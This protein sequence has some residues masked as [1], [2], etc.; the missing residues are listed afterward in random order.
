MQAFRARQGG[1]QKR[2]VR[3]AG[4]LPAGR[5]LK[6]GA[7]EMAYPGLFIAACAVFL[8]ADGLAQPAPDPVAATQK[9]CRFTLERS[10]GSAADL[11]EI[12]VIDLPPHR[13]AHD[14]RRLGRCVAP[15]GSSEGDGERVGNCAARLR[16]AMRLRT[17]FPLTAAAAP[18]I[19]GRADRRGGVKGGDGGK[20]ES[21]GRVEA[22]RSARSG[23]RP[24]PWRASRRG[25]ASGPVRRRI[26]Q[27]EAGRDRSGRGR[28]P[29][30]SAAGIE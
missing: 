22:V 17:A 21:P 3:R 2:R 19:H 8:A 9:G 15:G 4:G 1:R 7:A 20:G 6:P 25:R 18:V 12:W 11:D 30:R 14:A 27:A 26:R 13:R 29:C 23:G 16:A 10:S 28:A 24:G 5:I